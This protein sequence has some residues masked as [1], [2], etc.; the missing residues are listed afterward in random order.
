M[1]IIKSHKLVLSFN[2]KDEE[3]KDDTFKI[4]IKE[5]NESLDDAQIQSAMEQFIATGAFG[6]EA[7]ACHSKAGA[8]YVTVSA[9]PFDI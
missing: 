9:S 5:P 3:D 1:M 7:H 6:S 2:C 4:N 8:E